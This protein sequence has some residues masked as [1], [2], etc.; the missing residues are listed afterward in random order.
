MVNTMES[1]ATARSVVHPLNDALRINLVVMRAKARLSQTALAKRAAV[2]R[3]VIS[4]LEQGRGDVR[5]TTLARI[6]ASLN[7]TVSA[8]LEPWEPQPITDDLLLRRARETD[9]IPADALLKAMDEAAA[10]PR[11]SRRGRRPAT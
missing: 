4:E 10:I 8:L 2:S 6:A 1:M 3:A 7:V 11:Y 9:F 5:M